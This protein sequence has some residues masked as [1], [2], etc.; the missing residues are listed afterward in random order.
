METIFTK[1]TDNLHTQARHLYSGTE[2]MTD[3]PIDNNGKAEF[4][5]PTDL[6]AASLASCMLTIMGMLGQR[7]GFSIDGTEARI[8]KIMGNNPRRIV[9]IIIELDFPANNYSDKEKA[10]IETAAKTCPVAKSL[11]PDLKQTIHFHYH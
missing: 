7:E 9:E 4:F 3:A 10:Y 8:T 6:A 11:H 5:S 1:Y 2:I